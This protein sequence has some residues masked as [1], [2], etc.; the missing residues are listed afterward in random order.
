MKLG[1]ARGGV[2]IAAKKHGLPVMEY[3]PTKAKLSVTGN[4]R[5]SKG[6]VQAMIKKL[7]HLSK[8]PPSDAADALALALCQ[9]H[10][11]QTKGCEI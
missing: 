10:N 8:I 5:A 9:F 1:M 2:I 11:K 7:L 6:Q 4:G 3:S